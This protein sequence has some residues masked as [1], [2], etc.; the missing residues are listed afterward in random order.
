MWISSN[1][2]HGTKVKGIC[3]KDTVTVCEIIFL[4]LSIKKGKYKFVDF[5]LPFN[6]SGSDWN[7]RS[8]QGSALVASLVL[9]VL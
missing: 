9:S 3:F 1:M 4:P 5:E 8:L 7:E 6:F 2:L